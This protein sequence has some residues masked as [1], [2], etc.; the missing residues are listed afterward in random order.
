MTSDVD[1]INCR[2][3][4]VAELRVVLSL[5]VLYYTGCVLS[6]CKY[7]EGGASAGQ[8]PQANDACD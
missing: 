3:L 1:V 7:C 2:Q 8:C 6:V 5:Y 4:I